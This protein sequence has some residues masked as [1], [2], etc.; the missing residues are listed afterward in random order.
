MHAGVVQR[1]EGHAAGQRAI[2]DDGHHP[3]RLALALRG[4]RHAQRGGNGGGRVR[5]AE[6]VVRRLFPARK[7]RNAALL[8]QAAHGLAPAGEDLVRIG[9]MADVPH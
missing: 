5:R 4:K 1:L 3:A 8:P 2:A 9:L 6:G 7:T